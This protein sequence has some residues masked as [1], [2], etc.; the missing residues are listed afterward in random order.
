MELALVRHA[1][2]DRPAN[3]NSRSDTEPGARSRADPGLSVAGR[4]Q[5]ESLAE[6]LRHRRWDALYSSPQRRSLQ[7]ATVL[8]ERLGLELRTDPGLAEFDHG[9]PYIH[10]EDLMT[11][12]N[13]V[14]AAFRRE[15]FSAY[16]T[17]SATIRHNAVTAL[18]A[19]IAAHS[20]QQVVVVTH[21]TVINAFVGDFL[22]S[23]RLVFHHPAYTG[24]TGVLA[25]RTGR[26]EMTCLNDSSHLRLPWRAHTDR[27]PR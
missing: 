25:S 24:I 18:E 22:G 23:K 12:G 11:T 15:D 6:R 20:G 21:G 1:H 9:R 14:M 16:G 3:P 8:A 10:L 2:P 27:S 13:E 4:Q 5:A 26:R 19:I 17:D 7:T